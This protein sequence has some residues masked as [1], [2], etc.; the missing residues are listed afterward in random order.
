MKSGNRVPVATAGVSAVVESDVL[1]G[2][3]DV[4]DDVAEQGPRI[5]HVPAVIVPADDH[6]Q[7]GD[8]RHFQRQQVVVARGLLAVGGL[9]HLPLLARALLDQAAQLV[10][11]AGTQLRVE[12][13]EQFALCQLEIR[14]P[15]PVPQLSQVLIVHQDQRESERRNHS[16]VQSGPEATANLHNSST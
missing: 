7:T 5:R 15:A 4:R 14:L 13:D 1:V 12:V 10:D 8:L 11:L 6:A 2:R 16:L 9:R 3:L